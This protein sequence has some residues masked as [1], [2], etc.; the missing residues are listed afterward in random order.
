MLVCVEMH[1][2]SCRVPCDVWHL[3]IDAVV[4]AARCCVNSFASIA[5]HYI[6]A[7]SVTTVPQS[8]CAGC[9][10]MEAWL[11]D[12]LSSYTSF[13]DDAKSTAMGK[14]LS[15]VSGVGWACG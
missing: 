10:S 3:A 8:C 7:C 6:T 9:L 13:D 4:S 12:Q 14:I 5:I 2:G 1:I 15:E 11:P